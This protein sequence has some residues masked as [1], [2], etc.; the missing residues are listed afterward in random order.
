[1][2]SA[3]DITGLLHSWQAGDDAALSRLTP[4]VYDELHRLAG[5]YMKSEKDGHTLQATALVNEAFMR[6][7]AGEVDYDSRKHFF[8]IAARMMRRVLVDHARGKNRQ[9]RG[10]GAASLT[11][12]NQAAEDAGQIE[13]PII[14]LDE[15]LTSLA[16]SDERSASAIELIYFG[17]LSVDE[18]AD[19]LGISSTT[20][21]EDVRF[22]RA[23]IKKAMSEE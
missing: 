13:L 22:G 12:T 5:A 15:A 14:V 23:W 21:Y 3:D 10:D 6:L 4:M 9:K 7:S 19:A 17:G 1:M 16:G 11:L 2:S 8:V 20:A 18:A